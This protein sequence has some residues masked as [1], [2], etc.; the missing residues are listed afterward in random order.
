MMIGSD[1][2]MLACSTVGKANGVS[3]G[4]FSV[5]TMKS[6]SDVTHMNSPKNG[7]LVCAGAGHG[8]AGGQGS[9]AGHGAA[10]GQGSGAGHG[11]AGGQ[12]SIAGQGGHIIM[13]VVNGPGVIGALGITVAFGHNDSAGTMLNNFGNPL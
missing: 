1:V 7:L 8:A 9:G 13:P 5:G 3:F 4:N 2:E 6:T 12:G 11:A 10:G